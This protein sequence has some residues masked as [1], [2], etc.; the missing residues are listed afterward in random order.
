MRGYSG[1]S[2]ERG[3]ISRLDVVAICALA[4]GFLFAFD[5][6]W[7]GRLFLGE[8][9]VLLVAAG[10][11]L[12]GRAMPWFNP[13][14][15]LTVL[16]A[17]AV[18]L[19]GY[20]IADA[21]VASDPQ[22]Y[23][24]GWGRV[25]L[26]IGNCA[27]L[28]ML[29][30][31][32]PRTLWLVIAGLG[33]GGIVNLLS[34]GTPIVQWKLGYAEYVTYVLFCAFSLL[35]RW[36]A[37]PLAMSFGAVNI[38][39]DYRSIGAA[40]ILAGV[41]A[42]FGRRDAARRSRRAAMIGIGFGIG[43]AVIAYA[44]TATNTDFSK[45]REASNIGRYVG[46]LG[47]VDAIADAPFFGYG[48]WARDPGYARANFNELENSRALGGNNFDLGTALLPHSQIL[49]AWV[50][51]G[52]LGMVF[53][54]VYGFWLLRTLYWFTMWRPYD[55]LTLPFLLILITAAWAVIGSPFL[56]YTR[57]NIGLAFAIVAIVGVER[58]ILQKTLFDQSWMTMSRSPGG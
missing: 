2:A 49:Q 44:V 36:L 33:A 18:T 5:V 10:L 7:I 29:A 32:G 26:M 13:S 46:I 56:W 48:S 11:F 16:A 41:I 20:A 34:A 17:G 52:L 19:A 39:L 15:L 27:G 6:E 38:F 24:R 9:L 35:P 31:F 30:A 51:G 54:G 55:S 58:R 3:P 14:I 50:E 8:I 4:V 22:Q 23:L 57:I 45:R 12:S 40:C 1:A 43:V 47:A 28:I 37:I 42:A 21:I 25:V 53:F